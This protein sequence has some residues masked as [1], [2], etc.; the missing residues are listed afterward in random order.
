MSTPDMAVVMGVYNNGATLRQALDSV[1]GQAGPSFE[2][3]AVDDGSTDDSGAILD[4][5]ARRDKRLQVVH[6]SNAGLTNA[7]VDGCALAT[8]P[9]IVRQDADDVSLPGRLVTLKALA[10]A[11]PDAVLLASSARYIGPQGEKLYDAVCTSDPSI[12]RGQVLNGGIGPPAHGAVMFSR[13][14]Y[15]AVGG[16]RPCFYYGQDSDLWMRLAEIGGVAYTPEVLYCYRLSPG[17]ITGSQ[18][19]FQKSYGRLGQQC[20][21]ARRA[22]EPEAPILAEAEALAELLR[23]NKPK[24]SPQSMA[25]SYYHIASLLESADPSGA[26]EYFKQALS[27]DPWLWRARVKGWR[28]AW[29]SRP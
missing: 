17:A 14:S 29:R 15:E 3:V 4:E 16:Y 23:T 13:R 20:R 24:A 26:N 2:F 12:A 10:E 8:A 5:Y 1:L 28:A 19:A 7:L 21:A 22:W 11:N 25:A 6:K 9:W 18:R 27:M